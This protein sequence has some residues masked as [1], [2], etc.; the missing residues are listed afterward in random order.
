MSTP[1]NRNAIDVEYISGHTV[2]F[3]VSTDIDD[4][5]SETDCDGILVVKPGGSYAPIPQPEGRHIA[6]YNSKGEQ[7]VLQGDGSTCY[8]T[9]KYTY[10]ASSEGELPKSGLKFNEG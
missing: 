9:D 8:A 2:E 6:A 7:T 10:I 1:L 3:A 5:H 4:V